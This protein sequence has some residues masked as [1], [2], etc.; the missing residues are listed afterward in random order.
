MIA[1]LAGR[2]LRRRGNRPVTMEP[3]RWRLSA[4]F[5][6]GKAPM[7]RL[8]ASTFAAGNFFAKEIAGILRGEPE[9]GRSSFS[10]SFWSSAS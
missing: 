10:A 6:R 7:D 9:H 8:L 3:P 5:M 2:P 1:S 4:P